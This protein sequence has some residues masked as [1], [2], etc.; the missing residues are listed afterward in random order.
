MK[1]SRMRSTCS[2]IACPRPPSRSARL[3]SFSTSILASS[4]LASC[5]KV[6]A[7]SEDPAP[8][9]RRIPRSLRSRLQPPASMK[10]VVPFLKFV[11]RTRNCV[12]HPRDGQRIDVQMRHPGAKPRLGRPSILTMH[13]SICLRF[14]QE[15]MD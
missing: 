15:D 8:R 12:E 1:A 4:R 9:E 2:T 5:G 10:K 11:R 6:A 14:L 7:T 3:P 13:N